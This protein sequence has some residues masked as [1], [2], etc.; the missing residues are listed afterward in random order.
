MGG[1]SYGRRWQDTTETEWSDQWRQHGAAASLAFL[2]E[3]IGDESTAESLLPYVYEAGLD[4]IRRKIVPIFM[5]YTVERLVLKRYQT[6]RIKP[7]APKLSADQASALIESLYTAEHRRLVGFLY[8]RGAA[9]GLHTSWQDAEDLASESF[10]QLHRNILRGD[11]IGDL[12]PMLYATA[13]TL[14]S[15]GLAHDQPWRHTPT[16]ADWDESGDHFLALSDKADDANLED[17]AIKSEERRRAIAWVRYVTAGL[18]SIAIEVAE[19]RWADH[20]GLKTISD[21]LGIPYAEVYRLSW[22]VRCRLE[23]A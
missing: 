3:E 6:G 21:E 4:K 19:R 18:P 11:Q 23:A 7:Q 16:Q 2:T 20:Q 10:A 22:E 17:G 1:P 13:K 9:G 15:Q 8:R 14:Q 12:R 5:R